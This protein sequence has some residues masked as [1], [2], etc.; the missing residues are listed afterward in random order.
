MSEFLARGWNTC[1]HDVDV[2]DN[3]L[4]LEDKKGQFKRVQV[5]TASA[6]ELKNGYSVQF[7]IPMEQL[8]ARIT[9]EIHYVF[10]VRYKDKWVN[11]L[12]IKRK[13]LYK[14]FEQ[15]QIGSLYKDSLVLYI[16]FREKKVTCSQVDFSPFIDDFSEF[17][18]IPH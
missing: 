1:T 14:L 12:I 8:K 4:V 6:N 10:L 7:N 17:P 3:V 16:S 9:P 18:H 5:K 2:G 11:T 13:Q 15:S